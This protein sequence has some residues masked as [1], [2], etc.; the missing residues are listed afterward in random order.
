MGAAESQL[1]HPQALHNKKPLSHVSSAATLAE[2]VSTLHGSSESVF[3]QTEQKS[4]APKA[5]P[6]AVPQRR[7][8]LPIVTTAFEAESI[9]GSQHGQGQHPL[10]RFSLATPL[11]S[12]SSAPFA[13]L[14]AGGGGG[15]IAESPT[16]LTPQTLT[17]P[18][19]S[20]NSFTLNHSH[21][22]HSHFA[23]APAQK[24]K[25]TLPVDFVAWASF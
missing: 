24:P 6:I 1:Q 12:A 14:R 3:E 23:S 2:S 25:N 11:S 4:G 10:R 17:S 21:L 9:S 13:S 18:S 16:T 22:T 7:H 20:E 5:A 8:T 19:P 15:P